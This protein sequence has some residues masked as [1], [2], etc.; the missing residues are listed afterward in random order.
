MR[1]SQHWKQKKDPKRINYLYRKIIMVFIVRG[2]NMLKF[3]NVR[4][5]K[6]KNEKGLQTD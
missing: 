4:K 2:K 5:R 6:L 1:R 3:L